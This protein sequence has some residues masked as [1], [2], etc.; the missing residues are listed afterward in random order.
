MGAG[1][2]GGVTGAVGMA[3]EKGVAVKE[4]VQEVAKEVGVMEAG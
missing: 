4:G 3:A 2:T 1:E